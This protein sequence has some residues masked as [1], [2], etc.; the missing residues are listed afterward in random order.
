MRREETPDGLHAGMLELRRRQV[1]IGES[2][3]G[4][5]SSACARPLAYN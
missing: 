3:W 2:A 1:Y 5:V 4:T